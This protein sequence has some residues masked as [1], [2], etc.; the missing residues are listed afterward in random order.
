MNHTHA[1]TCY[2]CPAG[3]YCKG[4]G[5][6]AICPIGYY[7]PSGTGLD[8][9]S[10]PRGTYSDVEGLY[11]EVQCKPCP[12]GK[13]CDGEHLDA[14]TGDCAQGHWCVSGIDREYPNGV[15]KTDPLNNTCYDDRQVGFGG[16]CPVGS[17]CPGGVSSVFPI[18]CE[19]GTYADVEGL[20]KCIS[21]PEGKKIQF[22]VLL[23]I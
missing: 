6:N 8:W 18:P 22:A 11:A 23:K 1:V 4:Q 9:L 10:C 14:P 12:G 20:D 17:Y 5:Q 16:L 19:N 2:D 7:C 15:N 13:Y 21:C 3:Y